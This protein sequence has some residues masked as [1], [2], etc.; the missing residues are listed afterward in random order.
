MIFNTMESGVVKM[1][2]GSLSTETTSFW[3]ECSTVTYEPEL[4]KRVWG[5]YDALCNT[6]A[7]E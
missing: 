3:S 6:A 7:V 4:L 1:A 5:Q 2:E